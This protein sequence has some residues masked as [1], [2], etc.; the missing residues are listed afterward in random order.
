MVLA[1]PADTSAFISGT[2]ISVGAQG[3]KYFLDYQYQDVEPLQFVRELV[4]NG[5]EAIAKYLNEYDDPYYVNNNLAQVRVEQNPVEKHKIAFVDTGCGMDRNDF[6][7][8]FSSLFVTSKI[9]GGAANHG[10]G[11]RISTLRNNVYG[12][13]YI[14]TTPELAEEGLAV[15]MY[16]YYNDIKD[17]YCIRKYDGEEFPYIPLNSPAVPKAIRKVGHGTQVTLFG[18]S[19][20][21]NTLLAP[22]N[23]SLQMG[24]VTDAH[25]TS[26]Y[27]NTK[28]FN[29]SK[30][31]QLFAFQLINQAKNTSQAYR[32]LGAKP[33]L[34]EMASHK[35]KK[36]LGDCIIYYWLFDEKQADKI[37]AKRGFSHP[38]F[39]SK[40]NFAL[41]GVKFGNELYHINFYKPSQQAEDAIKPQILHSNQTLAKMFRDFG[42]TDGYQY[43][44]MILEPKTDVLNVEATLT[45]NKLN[46]KNSI[47]GKNE[48]FQSYIDKWQTA[49]SENLPDAIVKHIEKY[50]RDDD[51]TDAKLNKALRDFYPELYKQQPAPEAPPVTATGA[52]GEGESNGG[53]D[54]NTPTKKR[55]LFSLDLDKDARKVKPKNIKNDYKYIFVEPSKQAAYDYLA[56]KAVDF[57]KGTKMLIVNKEW[58]VYDYFLK[59]KIRT[60]FVPRMDKDVYA[61]QRMNDIFSQQYATAC[62]K[63][64]VLQELQFSKLPQWTEAEIKS[65]FDPANL[66][67]MASAALLTAYQTSSKMFGNDPTLKRYRKNN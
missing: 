37:R 32:V 62:M 20:D 56:G 16:I 66:S 23:Y 39:Y 54:K 6:K 63:A 26:H 46:I 14:S 53:G 43:V 19:I 15:K 36:D 24:S 34:D 17:T 61:I 3:T 65:L 58:Q 1:N 13:E 48:D 38:Y 7:K 4:K 64:I 59:S 51:N 30:E 10:L 11:A 9:Q 2:A 40:K 5:E 42:I 67:S 21:D 57:H 35:G 47:T 12:I 44:A 60:K 52:N 18:R 28:F 55:V 41:Y 33:A 27:L 49:F 29:I 45:R 22:E 31:F 8:Y 25:W 50:R